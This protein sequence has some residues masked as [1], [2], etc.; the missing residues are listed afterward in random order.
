MLVAMGRALEVMSRAQPP[1][2]ALMGD[3]SSEAVNVTGSPVRRGINV[4]WSDA[5]ATSYPSA[6]P[7]LPAARDCD[8]A[9]PPV[10]RTSP[11]RKARRLVSVMTSLLCFPQRTRASGLG[12]PA[13]KFAGE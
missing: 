7:S 4:R 1:E 11:P 9:R 3:L 13:P 6:C 5:G 10:A 2:V 12:L 8:A